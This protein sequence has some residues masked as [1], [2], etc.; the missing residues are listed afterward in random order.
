MT[1]LPVSESS[2]PGARPIASV[3]PRSASEPAGPPSRRPSSSFPALR[4]TE[5]K[6]HVIVSAMVP[7]FN[8]SDLDVTL[9]K[10]VLCITGRHRPELPGGFSVLRRGRR[11]ADFRSE[12]KL[13]NEVAW[14]DTVARL[15]RG[16]LTIRLRK[17]FPASR[18]P[19]PIRLT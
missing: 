9:T 2:L 18:P 6:E 19:V 8:E 10:D 3:V 17:D 7:G 4:L 16:V 11:S 5:T 1:R 13:L 12:I 14:D 15:E